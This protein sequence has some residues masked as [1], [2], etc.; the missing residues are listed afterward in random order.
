[1]NKFTFFNWSIEL[2]FSPN[3]L[4]EHLKYCFISEV[5]IIANN[6]QGLHLIGVFVLDWSSSYISLP[7]NK[8]FLWQTVLTEPS[9]NYPS[10]GI[11]IRLPFGC[12]DLIIS[13]SF[14]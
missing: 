5:F 2:L 11:T 9:T 12:P 3:S 6:E 14:S 4:R 7:N 8:L 13:V 10:I 1:M